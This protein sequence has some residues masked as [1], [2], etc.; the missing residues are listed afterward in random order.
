[1]RSEGWSSDL[2]PA[3]AGIE[4]LSR[5]AAARSGSSVV[6]CGDGKWAATCSAPCG[7][8]GV[9][10]ASGSGASQRLLLGMADG[11]CGGAERGAAAARPEPWAQPEVVAVDA[12]LWLLWQPTR[13]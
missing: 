9:A 10:R 6:V 2:W 13:R 11:R 7:V 12:A 5:A 1:V 8:C 3:R 4:A